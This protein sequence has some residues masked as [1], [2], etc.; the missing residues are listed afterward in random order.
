MA[1]YWRVHR[2]VQL[3]I[4]N[5]VFYAG[6]NSISG[7]AGAET[8]QLAI[9]GGLHDLSSRQP[10]IATSAIDIVEDRHYYPLTV[11]EWSRGFSNIEAVYLREQDAS[12][13]DFEDDEELL[14]RL[15]GG[16]SGSLLDFEIFKGSDRDYLVLP[17]GSIAAS[18]LQTIKSIVLRYT[19]PYQI[20]NASDDP[21]PYL[22]DVAD[23]GVQPMPMASPPVAGDARTINIDDVYN[24]ALLYFAAENV[25]RK[26]ATV[27]S[28]TVDVAR[29]A[30]FPAPRNRL[31]E[32]FLQQAQEYRQKALNELGVSEVAPAVV[33]GH[34]S[35][36][37][38]VAP[39]TLSGF[40]GRRV[41]YDYE[42]PV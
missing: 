30:A 37:V 41:G 31:P 17:A 9:Q 11:G 39:L 18:R 3:T 27:A 10:R 2:N 25:L 14:I 34:Q 6:D 16:G 35:Y 19:T 23:I 20:L 28:K 42:A 29:S 26:A 15:T 21:E 40:F 38:D 1:D 13:V 5:F 32:Q 22:A 8:I 4:G 24:R 33:V 7:P 12:V 36:A